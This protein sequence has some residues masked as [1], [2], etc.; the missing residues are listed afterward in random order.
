M[1]REDQAANLAAISNGT[2]IV[3]AYVYDGTRIWLVTEA[4]RS[5]TLLLADELLIWLVCRVI[6]W[7]C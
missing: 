6:P 1:D 5:T 2:R 7:R 4:D 3:S